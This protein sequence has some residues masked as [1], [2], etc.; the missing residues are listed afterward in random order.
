M[1]SEVDVENGFVPFP[2]ER[3]AFYRETGCWQPENHIQFLRRSRGK[4]AR[5]IALRQDEKA[6]SYDE[7]YLSAQKFAAY[8]ADRG[9]EEND[10]VL[11]Q[12]PNVIEF[13]VVL[14]GLYY[15]GARPVFC[16]DGHGAYEIENIARAS[17]AVGYIRILEP[18]Y[19]SKDA[20]EI[21]NQFSQ[22]N[23]G[24]WFRKTIISR[25]TLDRS[26]PML[27]DVN[28]EQRHETS[29]SAEGIAFL[30]LSGGT[31]GLPKLIA[32]T[33]ADYLYSVRSSAEVAR[34]NSHTVQLIV[35]P[36][37]HNFAMSSPGF[38]GAFHVGATVVLARDSS[39]RT[40]LPLIEKYAVTQVS[41]V[42]AIASLW[43]NSPVL[44]EHD[45]SS[46][47]VIQVGGAKLLPVLAEQIMDRLG[48][49]LQQ[50]YGM[51]E[52]LVNF[53]RLDDSR[54][55]LINTQGK[56][57]SAYDEIVI[58]DEQGNS[59]PTGSIGQILTRGPYTI[60]GYYNLKDVNKTSFTPDGFYKTGDIGYLDE[61][62][63]IVVTGRVKEQINRA[64]EKITP[65]EIEGFISEHPLVKDI[66]VLGVEDEKLG[67]RIKAVIILKEPSQSISLRDVRKFLMEKNIAHYKM[68]D[69]LEVVIDFKYTHVGKVH[70]QKLR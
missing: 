18:G 13:F 33:H 27:A 7:F 48:C 25:Q 50:V 9:I 47:Q 68:P 39:L 51:A 23:L 42:P 65:S 37:A 61:H 52:G 41:L 60:N 36:A 63:N 58:V 70:K 29:C 28:G 43:L 2:V 57:L 35:L 15:L 17:R 16:L 20:V 12:S 24:L 3:A 30:Q 67:E 66:C 34:L 32:R 21:T 59:K 49:T 64:G 69:E 4:Y 55:V 56:R 53:T 38:L 45:L 31:T 22:V 10:F 54:E 5:N 8:L 44:N 6:L 14:F 19:D 40:C 11:I 46:L 1:Y 26:L 62:N